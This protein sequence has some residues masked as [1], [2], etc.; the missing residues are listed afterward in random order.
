S[1]YR[2][3]KRFLE[4]ARREL[5]LLSLNQAFCISW[6]TNDADSIKSSFMMGKGP[7]R[8]LQTVVQQSL[9]ALQALLICCMG[10]PDDRRNIV[11][12]SLISLV[13]GLK[14]LGAAIETEDLFKVGLHFLIRKSLNDESA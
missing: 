4:I 10:M 9:P 8:D 6:K 12:G 14:E 2:T 3:L 13:A 1:A 7:P 11:L 5:H